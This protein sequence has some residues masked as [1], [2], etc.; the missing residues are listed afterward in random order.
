MF[1]NCGKKIRI[2]S[3]IQLIIGW[4]ASIV[5][6]FVLAIEWDAFWPFLVILVGGGFITFFSSL[7]IYGFG[8]IVEH[9]EPWKDDEEEDPN[10]K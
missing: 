5:L 9:V 6:A 4:I 7:I 10:A 3:I 2:I 8:I 1:D